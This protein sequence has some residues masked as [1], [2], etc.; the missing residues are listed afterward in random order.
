MKMLATTLSAVFLMASFSSC[1]WLKEKYGK[2]EAASVAYLSEKKSTPAK[3]NIEGLWYS[4]Q[5]GIVVFKQEARWKVER[6]IP[7]PLCR[8]RRGKR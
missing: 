8:Q 4:P 1:S 2:N 5:W 3:T 7:R 6:N